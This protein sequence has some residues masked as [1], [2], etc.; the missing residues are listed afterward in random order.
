MKD[1]RESLDGLIAA[2]PL[3]VLQFGA[4]SCGPCHAIRSRLDQW[5]MVRRETDARYVDIEAN[6]ALCTQ[7]GIFSVP[8]VIVYMDGMLVARESGVFSLNE[9]LARVERYME[10][11]Q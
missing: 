1:L 11:R 5:L 4:D 10:M 9:M 7:M 2:C 6:P 8:T 3:L